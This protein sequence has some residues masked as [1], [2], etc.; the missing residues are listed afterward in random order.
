M[1]H[2]TPVGSVPAPFCVL[3]VAARTPSPSAQRRPLRDWLRDESTWAVL[4]ARAADGVAILMP[5]HRRALVARA[6]ADT[7][8]RPVVLEL[9][10][11]A[12]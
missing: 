10:G 3:D 6:L 8:A 1:R 11:V 2:L 9:Q 5:S 12:Q 7:L 4:E